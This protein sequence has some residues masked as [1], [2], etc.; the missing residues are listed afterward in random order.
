MISPM[1]NCFRSPLDRVLSP[2][3][4][5]VLITMNTM[6]WVNERPPR[7]ISCS[8]N[9]CPPNLET[10]QLAPPTTAN[11][12][13]PQRITGFRIDSEIQII[14]LI[15]PKQH[16][17]NNSSEIA[18]TKSSVE[19]AYGVLVTLVSAAIAAAA[20]NVTSPRAGVTQCWVEPSSP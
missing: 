2:R 9:D 13:Q 5:G 8:L 1:E 14:Q 15:S 16:P 10:I 6:G 7:K 3:H 20:R 17:C 19:I 18:C 11:P 4:R 12:R